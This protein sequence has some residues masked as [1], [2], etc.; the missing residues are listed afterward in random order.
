MSEPEAYLKL[1]KEFRVYY[2]DVHQGWSNDVPVHKK[3]GIGNREY[4]NITLDPAEALKLLGWLREQEKTLEQLA[5]E[6][7]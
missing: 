3:V 1:G 2:V 7:Q 5:K 6:Q 4:P